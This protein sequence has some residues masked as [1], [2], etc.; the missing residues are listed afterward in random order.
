M[1]IVFGS[2]NVDMVFP[3]AHFPAAGETIEST[4]HDI[5][6]G[7][8]GANQALAAARFDTKVALVGVTGDDDIG[9]RML[10]SLRSQGVVT[11]GVAKLA[12]ERTGTAVIYVDQSG[13]NQIVIS[14]GANLK[15]H[16]DQLPDEVL[17]ADHILLLQMETPREQIETLILRARQNGLKIILNLAPAKKISADA[18]KALDYLIVNETEAAFVAE[19]YDIDKG[20]NDKDLTIAIAKHFGIDCIMTVGKNGS[21]L[22]RPDGQT[23]LTPT[24]ALEPEQIVDTTG[25]G[26]AFCGTFAAALHTGLKVEDALKYASVAG[27]LACTKDGAQSSYAYYYEINEK[28][29]ALL[30]A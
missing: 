28:V 5:S 12:D 2:I 29:Q 13:E 19:H 8:K 1:I 6:H 22:A 27:A 9:N 10:R 15:A 30:P 25:A 4:G 16:N 11:S 23:I 24:L 18:M 7:G 17:I 26:D 21:I 3:V 14:G 20:R